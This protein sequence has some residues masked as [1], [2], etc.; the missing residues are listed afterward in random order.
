MKNIIKLWALLTILTGIAFIPFVQAENNVEPHPWNGT[1]TLVDWT[2]FNERIKTLA[3]WK[4][5]TYNDYDTKITA[6]KKS[7]NAPWSSTITDNISYTASIPV[8]VRYNNGTIYYYSTAKNIYLSSDSSEMFNRLTKLTD[9]SALKE[10]D[11]S[12][13]TNMNSMFSLCQDLTNVS[14]LSNWDTSNVT[15]MQSMFASSD[16][17][18]DISW[19]SRWNTRKVTNMRSIFHNCKNLSNINP[20]GNWD[21]SNVID[22]SNMFYDCDLK[23]ISPIRNWDISKVTNMGWMF[24]RSTSL[25]DIS[26]LSNWDMSNVTDIHEMFY[27]C[28]DLKDI[29]PIGNWDTSNITNMGWV[30]AYTK[31]L[32]DISALSNWKTKKVKDLDG[33][34]RWCVKLTDASALSNWDT[35]NV[36]Y[37]SFIFEWCNKLKVIDLSNRNTSNVTD[38]FQMFK[39]CSQL[40]TIYV[41]DW[42]TTDKVKS[43]KNDVWDSST[44]LFDWDFELVWWNG[45]KYNPSHTDK[46]YARIDTEKTPWYFTK[47]WSKPFTTDLEWSWEPYLK[48]TGTNVTS[49]VISNK[50]EESNTTTPTFSYKKREQSTWNPAEILQN[51]YTREMNNAYSFAYENWIT[52]VSNIDKAKMNSS[53]TRIA[54]AKMLSNYAINIL[55]KEPDTSKWTPVFNDITNNLNNQYDNAVTLS[56]QLWIMWQN[57]KNN[58]FRPYDEVTRAE[59]ATALSRLLYNTRD[60]YWNQKYYEPHIKKLYNEWIISNTNQKI[61]EKR[62]YVMVML[63]R[64]VE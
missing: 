57:M 50:N 45:T 19:L 61:K 26:A 5:T 37:L 18:K 33:L 29:S 10:W 44:E 52:T 40:K 24:A 6:I 17:L 42:F 56:Y 16:N 36:I 28:S 22:M 1:A 27:S 41:W 62:W 4:K 13:V 30:F 8:Q 59:F 32:E 12:K 7:N 34:F 20:I 47:K 9:I 35:S 15:N 60:G 38:M 3:A 51:W 64:S 49:N 25:T 48:I 63:M 14:A 55:W 21:T 43:N 46:T 11:T 53:L 58:N 54:M 31:S 23:D 2:I 39:D